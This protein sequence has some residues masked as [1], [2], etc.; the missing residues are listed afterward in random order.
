MDEKISP[1][2]WPARETEGQNYLGKITWQI[3]PAWRLAGKY[4][5]DPTKWNNFFYFGGQNV[6][7]NAGKEGTTAVASIELTSVLSDKL[8]WY[9]TLGRYTYESTIYPQSGE[10][11]PIS[12]RNWDT[13][14]GSVNYPEQQYWDTTRTDFTTDLTWFVDDLAGSHELKGG[15]EYSDL[16]F[17]KA[18]CLTGTPNGE[19]CV[20]GGVG[21]RFFDITDEPDDDDEYDE[22]SE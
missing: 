17:N 10:L 4:T 8:S 16:H 21:F 11:A 14:E 20:A 7:A 19:R 3:A 9:T 18:N 22:D 13:G 2:G 6:E 5:S 12:Y 15:I 1:D